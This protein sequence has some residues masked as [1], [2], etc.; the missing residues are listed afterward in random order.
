MSDTFRYLNDQDE[1]VSGDAAQSFLDSKLKSAT[2]GRYTQQQMD[3]LNQNGGPSVVNASDGYIPTGPAYPQNNFLNEGK[4]SGDGAAAGSGSAD[5]SH[6]KGDSDTERNYREG[7]WGKGSLDAEGLAEKYGLDRS[8][9]GQGEGHI[10]GTN[11]DGSKV[12]IGKSNESHM[13][14]DELIKNHSKQANSAEVDHSGVPE[15][16]SSTGDVKGAILTEWKGAGGKG[17]GPAE[18]QKPDPIRHSPEIKQATERVR[19]YEND[20]LS[21]KISDDIFGASGAD[22]AYSFDH[23]K[24]STGIGTVGG[25]ADADSSIKATSS[26]LDAKKT[27]VKKDYNFKPVQAYGAQ[28]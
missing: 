8:E 9:E 17:G 25:N 27:E 11:P 5:Y 28:S 10:W 4:S 3:R 1:T 6:M 14:N 21:G 22:N 18:E 7:N 2:A 19:T 15:S 12:Y 20:V 26:F 13:S 24:G 23:N 16:L